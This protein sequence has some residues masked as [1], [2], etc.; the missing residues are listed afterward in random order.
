MKKQQFVV[1]GLGRFGSSIAL[2]LM[3]LNY[4][5]LGID[6]N[7]EIVSDMSDLLTYAVV[8]DASDEEVLKSLGVRN[9]DCGIVAIGEDIQTS[10]LAAILLKD[11]GVSTVIAKAI[12]VLHGRALEKLG[13]DRVVYP[14][15]DMGIRV[16]HQLV[17]PNLLDYI[18]LSKDYSIVELKV[19]MCL[20]GKTLTEINTRSRFGC[21]IVALH[22]AE[23]IIV[24]PTGMD[25][26]RT[27]DIMVIIGSNANIEQFENEVMHDN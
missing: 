3:A 25:Q 5:V 22:R 13:V 6:R 19:P 12:S 1:I 16:A 4:E 2:E 23:G 20:N 17:T 10:I 24:A 27:D 8:A 18:E 21:S 11:L 7:E 26:V 9:F 15:R 14:E